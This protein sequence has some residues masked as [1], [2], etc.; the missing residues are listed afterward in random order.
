MKELISP[1][2]GENYWGG[3]IKSMGLVFGDIGT[4]P[5]YTLT[6][7]IALNRPTPNNVLGILSLIIWTL[8]ILV[9]VQYGWLAM[10]LGYKEQ[11]GGIMLREPLHRLMKKGRSVPLAGELTCLGASVLLG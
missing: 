4:S 3:V 11:G 9:S 2:P 7:I 5:I 6:V 10:S 8:I 1:S